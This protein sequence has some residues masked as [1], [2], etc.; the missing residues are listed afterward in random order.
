LEKKLGGLKGKNVSVL[1][2]TFKGGTDDVRE[3]RALPMVKSLLEKGANVTGYDPKGMDHF[4][5]LIDGISYADSIEEALTEA[6]AC[7]IQNDW[8]E[9]R[10][11]D[12]KDFEVMKD[13][14]VLDGRRVL[15]EE[16]LGKEITYLSIGKGL[17]N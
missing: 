13:K 15:N 12:G 14:V 4:A 16:K 6:D 1:G 7:I 8:D 5:E 3:T 2:L 11:L 9:F 17:L 10:E